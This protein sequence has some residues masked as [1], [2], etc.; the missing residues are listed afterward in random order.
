MGVGEFVAKALDRGRGSLGAR[1]AQRPH[2]NTVL[3]LS[4]ASHLAELSRVPNSNAN[5][6]WNLNWS[7]KSMISKRDGE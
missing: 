3:L 6:N 5:S 7:R 1:L 2:T 4:E